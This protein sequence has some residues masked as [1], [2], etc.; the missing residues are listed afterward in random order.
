MHARMS[1]WMAGDG[2]AAAA[3]ADA[4]L[5]RTARR[6][7]GCDGRED[8]A[9][10][11]LLQWQK[12][13]DLLIAASLL[14]IPLELLYFATCAALAPLRRVLLQLGTFILMCG[15]THLLNALAYDR[16]G[17]RRVLLALTS[18]KGLGAVA[19]SAAAV[20]LPIF[21]RMLHIKVCESPT[22]RR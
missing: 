1:E 12:M 2:M 4:V 5:A 17:S 19:T 21:S 11:A 3:A 18:A 13:G 16:P 20:F 22:R 7:G 14:S 6:C 9:V 15:V 8:A 10:D